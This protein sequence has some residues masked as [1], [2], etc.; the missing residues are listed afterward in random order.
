[1]A[2]NVTFVYLGPPEQRAVVKVSPMATLRG[3]LADA[4]AKWR[5]ALDAAT[6]TASHNRKPVD[7]DVAFRL[8]NLPS[9]ARLDVA[10]GGGG[11]GGAGG[12]AGVCVHRS[13]HPRASVCVAHGWRNSCFDL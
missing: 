1:M 4:S 6:A 8:L 12:D 11:G 9:G 2:A 13:A 5:P 3:A 10:R 7:L